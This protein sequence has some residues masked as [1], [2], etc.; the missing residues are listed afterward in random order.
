MS[1][2]RLFRRFFFN[3]IT[4]LYCLHSSYFQIK[5]TI[6]RISIVCIFFND[7]ADKQLINSW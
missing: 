3:F 6:I 4:N 5:Q 1:L 2:A 7:K